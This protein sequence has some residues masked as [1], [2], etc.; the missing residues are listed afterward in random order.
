[1]AASTPPHKAIRIDIEEISDTGCE[2][3]VAQGRELL[4]EYGRFVLAQPNAAGFCFGSLEKEAERLPLSYR[5]QGGGCLLARIHEKPAGFVAWRRL[6]SSTEPDA[7]EMKRLWVRPEARGSGLGKQLTKAVLDRAVAAGCPA[8]Y[9][10]TV[11]EAM[12]AAHRMYLT[13]GFVA[14]AP[15]NDNPIDGITYLVKRF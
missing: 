1:M 9:L 8:V 12:A 15:Y 11:P 10:D 14:C 6:P 5:E 2:C 13:L 4:I 3:T 7:W